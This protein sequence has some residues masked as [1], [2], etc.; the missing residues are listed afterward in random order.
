MIFLSKVVCFKSDK[1][2]QICSAI[3][4][5]SSTL[6]D[7]ETT[8][9]KKM[10]QFMMERP[11]LGTHVTTLKEDLSGLIQALSAK[12]S[13]SDQSESEIESV[14]DDEVKLTFN[15]NF[16][17]ATRDVTDMSTA[18]FDITDWENVSDSRG[19]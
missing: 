16:G 8:F 18:N 7:L 2:A 9:T 3:S 1:K 10:E 11:E 6:G 17:N 19:Q 4:E 14:I 12:L 5:L 13:I 15:Y